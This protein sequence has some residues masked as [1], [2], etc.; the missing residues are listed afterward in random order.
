MDK[1]T[2]FSQLHC[3]TM[4]KRDLGTEKNQTKYRNM[5]RKPRV[6]LELLNIELGLFS[7]T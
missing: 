6:M 5:T 1:L 3:L 4:L 2:N 7:R